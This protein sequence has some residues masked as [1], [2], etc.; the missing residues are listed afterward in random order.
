MVQFLKVMISRR[1]IVNLGLLALAVSTAFAAGLMAN[2]F[3]TEPAIADHIDDRPD[4]AQVRIAARSTGNG[5][6]EVALQE[7]DDV[8]AWSTLHLPSARFLPTDAE[9]GR[10]LTSSTIPVST[11]WP[12]R[13]HHVPLT[14]TESLFG[15]SFYGDSR[16]ICLIGHG[17]P[18]QD[19]FWNFA[20]S[21]ASRTAYLARARLRTFYSSDG[22][23]QA[24]AIR[25]CTADGVAAIAATLADIDAVGDALRAAHAAG[26][27]VMTYNAG[28]S[29]SQQVNAFVH[30]GLNDLLGG[31]RVGDRLNE[32]GVSGEVWCLIHEARN[33]GLEERCDGIETTYSGGA[34]TRKRIHTEDLRA[35]AGAALAE[36]GVGTVIALNADTSHWV[37]GVAS[38]SGIDELFIGGFGGAEKLLAPLALG[39]LQF[40]VWDQPSI[41]GILTVNLLLAPKLLIGGNT[42]EAGGAQIVIEPIFIGQAEMQAII[43]SLPLESLLALLHTAGISPE[44]AAAIGVIGG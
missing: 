28:A 3:A 21:A 43:A 15:A 8:G 27:N 30:V 1:R 9:V 33:L 14:D 7:I 41:Q 2:Q 12:M 26:I 23:A 19:T 11:Y 32:A 6:I 37:L 25:K 4:N 24:A 44:E 5:Q 35:E 39:R 31:E 10:W 36:A 17:D 22:A 42:L 29:M 40:V 34:V 38:A 16:P 13:F 18:S 20:S